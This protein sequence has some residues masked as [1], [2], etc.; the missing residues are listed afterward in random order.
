MRIKAY[1]LAQNSMS[2][3]GRFRENGIF[4]RQNQDFRS[5]FA[6]CCA[7]VFLSRQ[8]SGGDDYLSWY[9][10]WEVLNGEIYVWIDIWICSV[11]KNFSLSEAHSLIFP[12]LT[13]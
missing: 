11:H 2:C 12:G 13:T 7:L 5:F 10:P 1:N 6:K 8:V 9:S 4:P 3:Q